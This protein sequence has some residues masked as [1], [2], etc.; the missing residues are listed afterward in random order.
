MQKIISFPHIGN[1]YVPIEIFLKLIFPEHIILPSPK[2]TKRTLEL[3]SKYSPDFVCVP[4]KYNLGNYIEA[5]ENGATVLIQVCGGCRYGYYA[6]IQEKI[7]K[8]LGYQFEFIKIGWGKFNPIKIYQLFRKTGASASFPTFIRYALLTIKMIEVLD[9]FESYIR[10]NIGF[11]KKKNSLETLHQQFLSDLRTVRGFRQLSRLQS[12]Y[13]SKLKTIKIE[14]PSDCLK[15]GIVGELYSLMEPFSSFFIEKE[16]SKQQ[17][18]VRRFITVTFLLNKL[19]L[20][21]KILKSAGSYLKYAI[22]AD[23]TDSVEKSQLL[24]KQGYDG[25]IH[26]KPFGC[27]PEVNAMP[28]LQ[29]ISNDYKIPI[30]YFSFDSQTSETGVKTRLEAFYDMLLMRKEHE[31]CKQLI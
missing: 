27:T 5:L 31:K 18:Q 20:D 25:I 30:L 6:E 8:D 21:K 3:G 26:M 24:A 11:E 7:L 22:G 19:K 16:L 1:Y 29:K 14:K 12:E 2:I 4:F 15:I 9:S 28:I 17:I 10:E 13:K 23:G